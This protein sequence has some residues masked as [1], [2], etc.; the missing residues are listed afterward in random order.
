MIMSQGRKTNNGYVIENGKVIAWFNPNL[1]GRAEDYEEQI[2]ELRAEIE[3]LKQKQDK[4][5]LMDAQR[6]AAADIDIQVNTK[7]VERAAADVKK[8]IDKA[9]KNLF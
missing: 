2:A 6:A 3:A 7:Q 9:L 4:D 8:E 5:G 1:N